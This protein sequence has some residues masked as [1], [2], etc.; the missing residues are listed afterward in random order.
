MSS[1]IS[2]DGVYQASSSSIQVRQLCNLQIAQ[3]EATHR[4][5]CFLCRTQPHQ[6]FLIQVATVQSN[7]RVHPVIQ[8]DPRAEG[9]IYPW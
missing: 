8:V 7:S 6:N 9:S 5:S 1:F 3:S 2:C 4:L